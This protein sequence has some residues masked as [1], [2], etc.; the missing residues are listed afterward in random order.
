MSPTSQFGSPFGAGGRSGRIGGGS[1][2]TIVTIAAAALIGTVV[3][4]ASA[5]SVVMAVVQPPKHNLR[6]DAGS[7][8]DAPWPGTTVPQPVQASNNPLPQSPAQIAPPVQGPSKTWPDALAQ[9]ADRGAATTAAKPAPPPPAVASSATDPN[10]QPNEETATPNQSA[11]ASEQEHAAP[12]Y[13]AAVAGRAPWPTPRSTAKRHA[14]FDSAGPTTPAQPAA[15]KTDDA[16]VPDSTA[17]NK[18][19]GD[20]P[21][22]RFV[23][24]QPRSP[25]GASRVIILP[26]P[27]RNADYADHAGGGGPFRLFD[28]AGHDHWNDDHRRSDGHWSNDRW[29][30]NDRD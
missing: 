11:P 25:D 27:Q 22:S 21:K 28:F 1:G 3:G 19:H 23:Q 29:N 9:R 7:T 14:A 16:T 24:Q 26:G 17:T 6:V 30:D 18:S 15:P 5:F 10:S 13:E 20:P 8:G 2:R 4:G 12:S